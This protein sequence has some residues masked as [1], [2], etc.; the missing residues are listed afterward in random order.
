M[1]WITSATISAISFAIGDALVVKTGIENKGHVPLFLSYTILMGLFALIYLFIYPEYQIIVAN[2]RWQ[3]IIGI[4]LLYIIAYY[5]H[6]S[7]L[8]TVN[9]PGYANALVMFH[10]AILS[11]ISYFYLNR[12]LNI[13]TILGI[14]LMFVG[15]FFVVQYN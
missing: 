13:L 8:T 14:T 9:N 2:Y 1:N 7:A 12:P 15:A 5:F 6:Y 11:I 10:V 4:T 3:S